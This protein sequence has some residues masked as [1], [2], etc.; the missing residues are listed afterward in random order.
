[1]IDT[2]ESL[3]LDDAAR[4]RAADALG[5]AFDRG[6]RS[7]YCDEHGR[8]GTADSGC[9]ICWEVVAIVIRAAEGL[10]NCSQCRGGGMVAPG[11]SCPTCGGN[12]LEEA[13]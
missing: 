5:E 2:S 9:E 6:Y 7:H 10:R 13:S 4:T 3:T 8:D 12:G 11:N 1:M